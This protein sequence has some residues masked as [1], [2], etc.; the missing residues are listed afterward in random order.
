MTIFYD[1]LQTD[2]GNIYV[3]VNETGVCKVA[4][5]EDDW[6]LYKQRNICHRDGKKCAVVIKQLQEYF[7]GN[8]R[9][10]TV[11]VSIE[12]TAFY[13]QVWHELSQIPY[14]H[15]KT[16]GDIAAAI[17]RPESLSSCGACEL[18]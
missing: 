7:S 5:T 15:V 13:H 14:G 8:L 4:V 11:P 16:Y 12:G 1:N 17:D 9:Q 18:S 10:F 2:F 3:A 6:Q